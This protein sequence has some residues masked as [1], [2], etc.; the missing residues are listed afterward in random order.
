MKNFFLLFILVLVLLSTSTSSFSNES[1]TESNNHD[2]LINELES[3]L[4]DNL[5]DDD[6]LSD[7]NLL[8]SNKKEPIQVYDPFEPVNRAIFTFNDK[9][10]TYVLTPVSKGYKKV[11]PKFARTGITNFFSN[12][13]SPLRICN[14]LLQGKF[15]N[16]GKETGAFFVNTF[17][18][19]LGLIDSASSIKG[20]TPPKEDLGQT[21]GSWGI[22]GGPYL[23]LPFLG[24]SNTRDTIAMT[25]EFF[26]DPIDFAYEPK[27]S[28][29]YLIPGVKIL[30][31]LPVKMDVYKTLKDSSFDPYTATRDAYN[32]LRVNQIKK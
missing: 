2:L 21:F 23:I 26:F 17:L 7:D 9:V 6:L 14:N 18:G 5:L 19:F 25:G 29:K 3:D 20:L 10:Y 27:D 12:L 24:P 31:S 4:G 32:Q 1:I 22:G 13:G 15:K 8:N 30:N 11:T 16:A 28:E